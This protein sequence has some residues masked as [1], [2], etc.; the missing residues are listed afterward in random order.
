MRAISRCELVLCLLEGAREREAPTLYIYARSC[1]H[2]T[3]GGGGLYMC[4]LCCVVCAL[5][6]WAAG[7]S[8]RSMKIYG[9][10]FPPDARYTLSLSPSARTLKIAQ[11]AGQDILSQQCSPLQDIV[12][13]WRSINAFSISLLLIFEICANLFWTGLIIIITRHLR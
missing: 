9:I 3:G 13:C 5:G 10:L 8:P 12:C 7:V 2:R 1:N 4:V 6:W 11:P